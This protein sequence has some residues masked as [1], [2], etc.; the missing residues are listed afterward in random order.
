MSDYQKQID[1]TAKDFLPPG[2][3]DKIIFGADLD[4]E[5]LGVQ[6]AVET[7]T[8]KLPGVNPSNI[9]VFNPE[10]NL[11]DS[12]LNIQALY[13]I[14]IPVGSIQIHAQNS[15]PGDYGEWMPC[16]G[17]A[18]SRTEYAELYQQ[19]G[20]SFGS[21]NGTS[22]FN[23]PDFRGRVPI[24][25]GNSSAPDGQ[26]RSRGDSGGRETVALTL[27]QMPRHNHGEAGNHSHTHSGSGALLVQGTSGI[28]PP[29]ALGYYGSSPTSVAGAHT[30][31]SQGNNQPHP[32][33]QPFLTTPFSIRV[34]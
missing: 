31:Q 6:E 32:N 15:M 14:F 18:L 12:G 21:G 24:G 22:T 5:L 13:D 29:T 19:I 10:G 20:T 33:M 2:H 4:S 30:H 7:K 11:A 9:P 23:L 28:A 8:D 3:P 26:N 25:T 27:A 34:R 1:F 17:Q 16:N